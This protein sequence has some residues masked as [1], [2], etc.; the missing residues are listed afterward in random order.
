MLQ[1]YRSLKTNKI[2]VSLSIHRR[3]PKLDATYEIRR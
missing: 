2:G 1:V 3:D